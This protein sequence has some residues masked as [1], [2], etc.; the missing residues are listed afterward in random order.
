M[1]SEM[2]DLYLRVPFPFIGRCRTIRTVKAPSNAIATGNGNC[3]ARAQAQCERA[4]QCSLAHTWGRATATEQRSEH[5]YRTRCTQTLSKPPHR[6]LRIGVT[7][8]GAL[9]EV[10]A[11]PVDPIGSAGQVGLRI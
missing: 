6:A 1:A 3:A 7:A 10:Y 9:R 4:A 11:V 8:R 5:T 2:R